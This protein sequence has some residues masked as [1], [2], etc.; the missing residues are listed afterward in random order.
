MWAIHS[1]M[2]NCWM[3]S[4]ESSWS[5]WTGNAADTYPRP[6]VRFTPGVGE[7]IFSPGMRISLFFTSHSR[8]PSYLSK[9][10]EIL[11]QLL[12]LG[13]GLLALPPDELQH[14]DLPLARLSR[15]TRSLF[16]FSFAVSLRNTSQGQDP[17]ARLVNCRPR[18][19]NAFLNE[20]RWMP[21]TA[22]L[23]CRRY[24]FDWYA[25]FLGSAR[26]R[27]FSLFF[28]IPP[29][30]VSGPLCLLHVAAN[31]PVSPFLFHAAVAVALALSFALSPT[32]T[33]YAREITMCQATA[34]PYHRLWVRSAHR[35]I[36]V[37][38]AGS[39]VGATIRV[40]WWRE[41]PRSAVWDV[42]CTMKHKTIEKRTSTRRRAI[43]PR[44][45]LSRLST[46]CRV[47]FS[48]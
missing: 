17:H 34:S 41:I 1:K 46:S 3:T 25:V 38:D 18:V 35:S 22:R 4:S 43:T 42:R 40:R 30:H 7:R 8:F 16:L 11:L 9:S 26:A 19:I 31:P 45:L 6:Y 23:H 5:N 13:R 21:V 32:V 37:R 2:A 29:A 24:L 44:R 14:L 15:C 47:G 28:D 10:E 48:Y 36:S 27:A 39:R 12:P 33:R 20:R